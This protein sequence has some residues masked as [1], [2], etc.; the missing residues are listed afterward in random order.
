MVIFPMVET[1]DNS[2]ICIL[3]VDDDQMVRRSVAAYLDDC[4]YQVVQAGD[5]LEALELIDQVNPLLVITDLKMPK[6]DGITLLKRIE[7]LERDI[8]VIVMSGAGAMEDAVE[9]LRSGASDYLFKPIVD[10]RLLKHAIKRVSE[11][12]KLQQ[13]NAR[14]REAL[15]QANAELK[16]TLQAL[17]QDQQAG[18]QLQ[19]KLFPQ[20][21]LEVGDYHFSHRIIPSLYLSGDF[22]EY[23]KL[24]DEFLGFYIADV[25]GHGVSSAIVTAMLRHFSLSV[26]RETRWAQVSGKNSPFTTPADVLAYYNRELLAADIDKHVTMFAAV[27]HI[28]SNTLSYSVAGHL[29]LPIL[30]TADGAHYLEGKGMPLGILKEVEYKNYHISLPEQFSLMLCSDGVLEQMPG[31]GLLA[32]EQQLLARVAA[33]DGTQQ[34]IERELEMDSVRDA[35]DD[36]AVMTLVKGWS[37]SVPAEQK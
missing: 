18:R 7:P 26:Y 24:S 34:G 8:P 13:Q 16:E 25:S 36:I 19:L 10:F 11:R 31:A 27:L 12:K 6:L 21:D 28:P 5:G 14:Y 9:A 35:P 17:E 23:I 4:G 15:E 32:K 33:S 2:Q 1:T 22:L 3:L 37:A 30:K 29:P 20:A